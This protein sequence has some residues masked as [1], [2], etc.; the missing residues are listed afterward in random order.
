MNDN[1]TLLAITLPVLLMVGFGN[2]SADGS[3]TWSEHTTNLVAPKAA[4]LRK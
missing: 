1:L 3:Y 4:A 2:I